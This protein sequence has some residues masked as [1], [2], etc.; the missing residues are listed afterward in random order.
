MQIHGDQHGHPRDHQSG[1]NVRPEVQ[2]LHDRGEQ[3]QH[4]QRDLDPVEEEAQQE[5][6]PHHQ[7]QDAPRPE[8]HVLNERVD[9]VVSAQR[10]ENVRKRG[11]PDEDP[12]DH[13]AG[14]SGPPDHVFQ[15]RPRQSTVK[16][17]Q[18]DG[19]QRADP[20]GLRRCRETGKDRAQHQE[21]QEDRGDE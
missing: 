1:R 21:D 6:H 7:E 20:G 19:A 10:P 17:R 11:R 2:R 14:Q 12:E 4:D 5:H 18:D 9:Q 3:R 13:G 8:P 16:H 15:D